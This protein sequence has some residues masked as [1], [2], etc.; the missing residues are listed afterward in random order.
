[1][2]RGIQ[3]FAKW[4][5]SLATLTLLAACTTYRALPAEQAATLTSRGSGEAFAHSSD[6]Y[7][8]DNYPGQVDVYVRSDL[9]K[10]PIEKLTHRISYPNGIFINQADTLFVT[11][12]GGNG[13]DKVLVIPK[14]ARKASLTYTGLSVA[15]DVTA[16]SGGVVYV[17]D[18][19]NQRVVE[20]GARG[21]KPLRYIYPGGCPSALALSKSNV[22]YVGYTPPSSYWAQ[23]KRYNAGSTRGIAMLAPK[24]VYLIGGIALD[25][26]GSLLVANCGAGLIDIFDGNAKTPTRV[27]K[28]GQELPFRMAFNPRGSRLYV[29]SPFIGDLV[30]RHRLRQ[31]VRASESPRKANTIVELTY[32]SGKPVL[33]WREPRWL[34]TGI[35][36]APHR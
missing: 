30:E 22:L 34:P 23:V 21:R 9:A 26:S 18:C 8:S 19:G 11:S 27:M 25:G 29:T 32:P 14:G 16:S 12:G 7:V 24:V 13:H 31:G 28:T 36:I 2:L 6:I 5:Q 17:A 33:T 10:G 3:A 4:S 35:A 15:E 20:F 1:V